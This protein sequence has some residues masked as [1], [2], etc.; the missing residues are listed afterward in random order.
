MSEIYYPSVIASTPLFLTSSGK[1]HFIKHVN[2]RCD[3]SI[4]VLPTVE[5][6][7]FDFHCHLTAVDNLASSMRVD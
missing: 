1:E 3:N 5:S 7:D 4:Q 2:L 6:E